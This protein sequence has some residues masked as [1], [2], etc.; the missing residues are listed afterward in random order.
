MRLAHALHRRRDDE[1]VAGAEQVYVH[2]ST[3]T[4]KATPMDASVRAR[5]AQLEASPGGGHPEDRRS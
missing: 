2:V 3:P 4:G 1:L 5:L